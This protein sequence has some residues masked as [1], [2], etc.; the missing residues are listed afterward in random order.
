MARTT[1]IDLLSLAKQHAVAGSA[2]ILTAIEEANIQ[3][4]LATHQLLERAKSANHF[5]QQGS[6]YTAG[7]FGEESRSYDTAAARLDTLFC[8]LAALLQ[9]AGLAIDY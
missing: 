1:R 6:Y 4:N 7:S 9:N 3:V 5:K 8:T 2:E